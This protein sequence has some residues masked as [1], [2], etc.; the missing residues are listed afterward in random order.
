MPTP[1]PIPHPMRKLPPET[2]RSKPVK[3]PLRGLTETRAGLD[4]SD[5]AK[6]NS[7]IQRLKRIANP[8]TAQKAK[9]AMYTKRKSEYR[10]RLGDTK[11]ARAAAA[12][13][14]QSLPKRIEQPY[15]KIAAKKG[16]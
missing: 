15:K 6:V 7:Y 2:F 1:K 11:A 16:K 12:L 10:V 8:T 4:A 14:K 9:L 13:K 3:L 5:V